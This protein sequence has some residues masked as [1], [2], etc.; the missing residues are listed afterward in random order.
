MSQLYE[1]SIFMSIG[2]K[3]FQIP[4]DIFNDP[5]NSP[6]FFS[7]GFA[8]FF[9]TPEDL[10]PGLNREH[11]IR[12]PSIMPPSV[13]NRSADV[14]CELLHLLRGYPVHIRNEEHRSTLLRDCRYFNFKGLEQKL[15]AHSIS[16]NQTRGRSEIVLRLEDILKSGISVVND[17][18]TG[19]SPG[20]SV[21]GWVNYMRPWEDTTAF[22]LVLEIGGE[23]TKL[24]L[25]SMRAEFFGQT[26]QRIAR[27][28]EVIAVK[29]K[30]PPT[31]QPL[32]LL[33]AS[34]GAGSQ[35]ASPGNTP[36]SEDLVRIVIEND[37]HIILDGKTYNYRAENDEIATAMSA[38]SLVGEGDRQDSPLS[39]AGGG[40]GY[41]LPPRKRRRTDAPGSAEE[42][43]VRTGQWRL[44]IQGSRST[45]GAVECVL[46][47]VKLDAYSSELARNAQRGF[48][49]G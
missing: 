31:T 46:I 1:A 19:A 36:L 39:S 48:L 27:L 32:G 22:E 6:N 24:Y 49:R 15:I 21:T 43:V 35:P 9:S 10:F 3:E 16:Y 20:E 30:L 2:H 26:K 44:K 13:P 7:L 40:G 8:V 28:F 5:G 11:L 41:F 14:F 45:R 4:R 38:S 23:N 42:W 47:A 17:P 34:G 37:T 33:M 25:N 29:L 18:S 12:P